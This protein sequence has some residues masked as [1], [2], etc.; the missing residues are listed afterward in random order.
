MGSAWKSKAAEDELGSPGTATVFPTVCLAPPVSW[1]T[2]LLSR[3]TD[4]V[5]KAPPP[6]VYQL[7]VADSRSLTTRMVWVNTQECSK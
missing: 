5:A 2:K 4:P 3:A 6:V 7:D 1:L